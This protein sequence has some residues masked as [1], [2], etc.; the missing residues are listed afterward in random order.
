MVH[1]LSIR[2]QMKRCVIVTPLSLASG[3]CELVLIMTQ[4]NRGAFRG[5]LVMESF[6]FHLQATMNAPYPYGN[7]ISGLALA[8]SAVW[9]LFSFGSVC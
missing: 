5:R 2:L 7:P 9:C 8:A 1:G 4:E 3:V 6:A